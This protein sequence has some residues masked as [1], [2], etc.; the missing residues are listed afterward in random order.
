MKEWIGYRKVLVY[1]IDLVKEWLFE[2][3]EKRPVFMNQVLKVVD[4]INNEKILLNSFFT[5]E[6]VFMPGAMC[7]F[8]QP[9]SE[10]TGLSVRQVRR[11]KEFMS[12]VGLVNFLKTIKTDDGYRHLWIVNSNLCTFVDVLGSDII[13]ISNIYDEDFLKR[14][15]VYNSALE[16]NV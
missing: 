15:D 2:K 7:L 12:E 1:D 11:V 16:E 4:Y 8:N 6:P 5:N 10:S 3:L 13:G 9:I 14:L